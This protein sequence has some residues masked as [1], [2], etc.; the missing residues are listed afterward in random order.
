M[1]TS[2]SCSCGNV[3][4]FGEHLAGRQVRCQGCQATGSIPA[5]GDLL[6]TPPPAPVAPQA[7]ARAPSAQFRKFVFAGLTVSIVGVLAAAGW[8]DILQ[9]APTRTTPLKPAAKA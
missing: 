8:S 5:L 6:Q 4:R 7:P 3:L 2:W 1:F 9:P